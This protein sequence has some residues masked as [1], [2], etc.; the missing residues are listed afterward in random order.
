MCFHLI[1]KRWY[2]RISLTDLAN[3]SRQDT[4]IT[5]RFIQVSP[6]EVKC[7]G[8]YLE[9]MALLI[10]LSNDIPKCT[11]ACH[12]LPVSCLMSAVLKGCSGVGY[13]YLRQNNLLLLVWPMLFYL[14]V[15]F[16]RYLVF[17]IAVLL[18]PPGVVYY[19]LLLRRET[20][21]PGVAP[22]SFRIGIWDLFVHRGQKSYTPTA[23][24]K[25]RTTPGVRCMKHASS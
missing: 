19:H 24:G 1:H 18:Y 11:V 6:K 7:R 21:I 15:C 23:F 17:C 20:R 3:V 25:L 13:K 8:G 5:S 14:F 22:F 2:F 10:L 9:C 12:Y 4:K 16:T